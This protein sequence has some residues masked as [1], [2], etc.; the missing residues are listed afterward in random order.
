[1]PT[2]HRSAPLTHTERLKLKNVAPISTKTCSGFNFLTLVSL[3]FFREAKITVSQQSQDSSSF[4]RQ[5]NNIQSSV[6]CDSTESTPFSLLECHSEQMIGNKRTDVMSLHLPIHVQVSRKLHP[7]RG[8][9]GSHHYWR[10]SLD[11]QA[12]CC[13]NTCMVM[14]VYTRRRQTVSKWQKKAYC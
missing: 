5:Q 9:T 13:W 12:W 1:M 8:W 4:W 14:D 6:S 10:S 2:Q 7:G 3:W 11:H